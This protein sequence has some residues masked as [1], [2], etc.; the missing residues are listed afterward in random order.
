LHPAK[1]RVGG[2]RAVDSGAKAAEIKV[3]PLALKELTPFVE[4]VIQAKP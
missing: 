1:P 4:K 2:N 3:F